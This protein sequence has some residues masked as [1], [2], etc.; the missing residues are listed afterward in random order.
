M[1]TRLSFGWLL[2]VLVSGCKQT[3]QELLSTAQEEKM[4]EISPIED[5]MR[6]HGV[7]ARLLLIGQTC[8]DKLAKSEPFEHVLLADTLGIMQTFI[9]DYHE[10]LEEEY[11]FPLFEKANRELALVKTLLEQ[12]ETGRRLVADMQTLLARGDLKAHEQKKLSILLR[13]LITMY[14]PHVARED[15]V[16]YPQLHEILSQKEIDQLGDKFEDIEHQK[17]GKEGFEEIVQKVAEIEKKLAI[18]NLEQFTPAE[19]PVR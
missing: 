4:I 16:L 9:Q 11:I 12:H 6:E 7:L 2:L 5:L 3:E 13:E 19:G 1:K 17:F 10:K 15:T 18:Y 8:A 14:R